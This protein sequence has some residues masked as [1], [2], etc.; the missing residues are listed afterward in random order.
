MSALSLAAS[1]FPLLLLLLRERLLSAHD[2]RFRVPARAPLHPLLRRGRVDG[3]GV[4]IALHPAGPQSLLLRPRRAMVRRWPAAGRRHV[5][6]P[7]RPAPAH[8]GRSPWWAVP[9]RPITRRRSIS[10]LSILLTSGQRGG[11]LLAV[12]LKGEGVLRAIHPPRTLALLR[13]RYVWSV[14][15]REGGSEKAGGRLDEAASCARAGRQRRT[16]SSSAVG[17]MVFS[18]AVAVA[19]VT[20]VDTAWPVLFAGSRHGFLDTGLGGSSKGEAGLLGGRDGDAA[21]RLR[22]GLLDERLSVRPPL[23]DRWPGPRKQVDTG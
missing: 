2:G 13:A 17:E 4:A 15:D 10:R 3:S 9:R 18:L 23:A 8:R 20:G 14:G 22:N 19:M 5:L 6:A 12:I 16:K 11:V 21:P 1:Q 7:R